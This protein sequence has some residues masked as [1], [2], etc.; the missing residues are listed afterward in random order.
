MIDELQQLAQE[1]LSVGGAIA[2]IELSVLLEE[3]SVLKPQLHAFR[4]P[5]AW[6][7]LLPCPLEELVAS[8]FALAFERG[9]SQPR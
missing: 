4:E 7:Q 2:G 8:L 9:A 3:L 1:E 5:V 6:Q